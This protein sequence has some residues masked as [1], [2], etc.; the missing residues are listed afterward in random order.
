MALVGTDEQRDLIQGRLRNRLRNGVDQLVQLTLDSLHLRLRGWIRIDCAKTDTL[1][2]CAVP[3]IARFNAFVAA[4]ALLSIIALRPVN[5][6][7]NSGDETCE[8]LT[9]NVGS[10]AIAYCLISDFVLSIAKI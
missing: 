2:F 3:W 8:L 10:N 4:L 1:G 7:R 9:G 6:L 5:W